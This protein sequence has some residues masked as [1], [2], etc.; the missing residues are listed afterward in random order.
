MGDGFVLFTIHIALRPCGRRDRALL[1]AHPLFEETLMK[2]WPLLILLLLAFI[3]P[4]FA[5]TTSATTHAATQETTV[6]FFIGTYTWNKS[7]GIYRAEL[8][9]STGELS[10]PQLVAE[11]GSPNF[12]AVHPS[13]RFLFAAAEKIVDGK[14]TSVAASFAID[15]QTLALT[16]INHRPSGGG[17]CHVS[18]DAQGRTLLLSNYGD[19]SVSI[20]TID[21]N[22]A[23]HPPAHTEWHRGSGPDRKR[24]ESA[25]AH[26]M[27]VDLSGKFALA[28]DL[29]TDEV[30]I[31]RIDPAKPS[32]TPHEPKAAKLA[33]GS[34]PR[35]LAFARSGKVAYVINE[36]A[37]T[38]TAFEWDSEKGTLT[39]I[40]TVSTLPAGYGGESYTAEVAVHP[41]G[42]FLYASNRGHDSIAVFSIDET[43]G[44]LA[45]RSTPS[46][47]GK[48]PRHFAIDPS[49]QFLIVAN[50]NSDSLLSMKIDPQTGDLTPTG[51]RIEVGAPV[52]VRFLP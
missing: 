42:R 10:N 8:N 44:K 2:Y 18:L 6:P 33:P 15:P 50:Q 30:R 16:P 23:L 35:H 29:G 47:G 52:C 28:C 37:N 45:L 22:G 25:H 4:A 40:Q 17:T 49:G 39:E 13:G 5:Q 46:T 27:L 12:L 32:I 51:S 3:A 7:K 26:S 41:S 14:N 43:T 19:G 38:I 34:G 9:P 24:Q 1:S 36:L 20:M 11:I 31:Y 48:Y 21:P